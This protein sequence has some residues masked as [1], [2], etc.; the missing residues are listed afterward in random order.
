[1]TSCSPLK[2][3]MSPP[4]WCTTFKGLHGIISQKIELFGWYSFFKVLATTYCDTDKENSH[5]PGEERVLLFVLH[6][7]YL[8]SPL[9]L[10]QFRGNSKHIHIS[11]ATIII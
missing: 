2:S 7:V 6:M 5:I 10:K 1:M 11:P 9:A 4:K 8:I 3:N